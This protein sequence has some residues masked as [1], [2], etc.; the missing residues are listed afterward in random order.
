MSFGVVFGR[1]RLLAMFP[2]HGVAHVQRAF[3]PANFDAGNNIS[4]DGLIAA[5][6]PVD[7]IEQSPRSEPCRRR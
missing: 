7:E 6:Q 1:L 4:D 2:R 5:E 3:G